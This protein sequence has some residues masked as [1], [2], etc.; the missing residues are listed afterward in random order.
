MITDEE[1]AIIERRIALLE[2]KFS[3]LKYDS[4][5]HNTCEHGHTL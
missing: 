3:L 5:Q 1:L 4:E 2:K